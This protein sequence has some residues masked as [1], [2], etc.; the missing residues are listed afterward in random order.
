MNEVMTSELVSTGMS[1]RFWVGIASRYVTSELN[2]LSL[3]SFQGH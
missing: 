2:Q 1:D 3:A